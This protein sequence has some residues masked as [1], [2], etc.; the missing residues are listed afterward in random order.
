M[1]MEDQLSCRESADE[2][3]QLDGKFVVAVLYGRQSVLDGY[4]YSQLFFQFP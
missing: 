3:D 4:L 2:G 1:L